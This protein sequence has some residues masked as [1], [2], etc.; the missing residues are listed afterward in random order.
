MVAHN[1][2]PSYARCI[3]KRTVVQSQPWAKKNVSSYL[4]KIKKKSL[5][6]FMNHHCYLKIKASP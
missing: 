2:G 3:C 5:N 1:C 6:N 4:K